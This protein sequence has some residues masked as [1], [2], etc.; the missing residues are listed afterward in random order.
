MRDILALLVVI[1]L[2]ILLFAFLGDAESS[3]IIGR[4]WDAILDAVRDLGE[5]WRG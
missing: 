1:A 5:A 2:L 3:D 4:A